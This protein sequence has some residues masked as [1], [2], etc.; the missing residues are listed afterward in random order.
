[1]RH[2]RTGALAAH[3]LR[4]EHQRALLEACAVVCKSCGDECEGHANMHEH[5][6]ICAEACRNCER[7]CRD[8]LATIS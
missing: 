4:R 6:R 5:C 3:R 2:D 7:V 1:L 8:L